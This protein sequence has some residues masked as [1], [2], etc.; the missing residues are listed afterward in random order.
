MDIEE[1]SEIE[2][3][4]FGFFVGM[5]ENRYMKRKVVFNT[6]QELDDF[7][8]NENPH[9]CYV[10]VAFYEHPS[11]M[12]GWVG[13]QLFF[14][15]DCKEDLKL[16]YADALTVYEVLLDDFALEEVSLRFSGS[17]G[18]HV[19]SNDLEPRILVAISRREICDY[20]R[21]KYNVK[22]IDAP[23]S[24]DIRRLRR[25]AGTKN[26]KSGEYCRRIK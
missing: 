10:S 21:E 3:R 9:D 25:I 20:M 22:T 15:I 16:A 14:D 19:I 12:E 1:I 5:G 17:K 26:S 7:I 13:A 11:R 24:T 23:A 2:K 8:H 18:Y 6:Q 4:E